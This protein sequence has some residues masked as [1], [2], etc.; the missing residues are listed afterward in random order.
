MRD[1][2][3]ST[4]KITQFALHFSIFSRSPQPWS[5]QTKTFAKHY[6]N[7][8]PNTKPDLTFDIIDTENNTLM[9]KIK[10]SY[11]IHKHKPTINEKEE[12]KDLE[13]YITKY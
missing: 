5:Y 7:F 3:R 12:L 1:P 9:R 4:K 8:Y 11:Y 6:N 13:K 2:P 10:E